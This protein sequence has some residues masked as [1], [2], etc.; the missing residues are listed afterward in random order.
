[1]SCTNPKPGNAT[2]PVASINDE[3]THDLHIPLPNT[4]EKDVHRLQTLSLFV[5]S[6]WI[7]GAVLGFGATITGLILGCRVRVG[8]FIVG[9]FAFVIPL[10]YVS[11]SFVL[12]YRLY[13]F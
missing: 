3:F 11:R 10:S 1:V 9:V 6:C 12:S 5:F 8:S 13:S 7:I 4:V 2:N